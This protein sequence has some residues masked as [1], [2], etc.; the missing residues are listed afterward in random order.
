VNS[1]IIQADGK[2]L[3][4]GEFTLLA[5]QPRSHIGRL[6]STGPAAENLAFDGATITWLR[7]G[8][9][10]EIWHANFYAPLTDSIGSA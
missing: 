5:G 2:I 9:S 3:V 4:G 1:V 10:P 6:N 8:T 7:G